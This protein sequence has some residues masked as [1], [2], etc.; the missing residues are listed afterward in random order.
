MLIAGLA[1]IVMVLALAVFCLLVVFDNLPDYTNN[2]LFVSHVLSM[3]TTFPGNS[4]MYRS[5]TC[6]LLWQ[7]AYALI[8][9][10]EVVG[11]DIQSDKF[12]KDWMLEN[13]VNRTCFT[14]MRAKCGSHEMEEVGKRLR[15]MMPRIAEHALVDKS[16]N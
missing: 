15:A 1:K 7:V 3:G 14:A 13:R 10:N 8:I 6:P 5:I 9:V 16:K 4:L 11:H 2:Y 12:V